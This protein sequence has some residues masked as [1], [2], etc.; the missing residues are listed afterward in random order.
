MFINSK[1]KGLAEALDS[2]GVT[3]GDILYVS[4]DIKTFLFRLATEFDIKN[5][6]QRNKILN[7][8]VDEFQSLVSTEGTLLFPVFSWD[9]CRGKGFRTCLHKINDS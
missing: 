5:K 9:W 4:S 6:E 3:K 8:L 7:D 1:L 2:L